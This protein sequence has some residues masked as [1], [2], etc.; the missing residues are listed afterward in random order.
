MAP[1][2]GG[3]CPDA[4]QTCLDDGTGAGCSCDPVIDDCGD[5]VG[6][7]CDGVCDDPSQQCIFD[8]NDPV[9]ECHCDPLPCLDSFYPTC[10]GVCPDG[11]VCVED[12]GLAGT[13]PGCR[14]DTELCF[15]A[16]SG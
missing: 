10:D 4:T 8:P 5:T 15:S 12:P 11:T 14:C 7:T 3:F 1:T 9:T 6:P 13:T 16:Q 2:C